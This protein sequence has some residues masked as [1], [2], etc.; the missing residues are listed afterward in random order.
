MGHVD[1]VVE[2]GRLA[3]NDVVDTNLIGLFGIFPTLEPHK[4]HDAGAVAEMGYHTFFA[5]SHLESLETED[6]AHD[7]YE[8]HVARQL[9]DGIDF[10][11][12][13]IFIGVSVDQVTIG[14][15]TKFF[16]QY[17]FPVRSHPWQIL[18][19]LT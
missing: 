15:D 19:V 9:V 17:L 5:W 4:V 18:Y 14:M 16:A 10:G 13:D 7:L 2:D 11:T 1:A 8:G 12:V 3:E 6:L